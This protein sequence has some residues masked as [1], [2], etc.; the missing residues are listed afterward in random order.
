MNFI[1]EIFFEGRKVSKPVEV[2][3]GIADFFK[4]HFSKAADF[5]P[6][7]SGLGLKG[8]SEQEI[9]V[10]ENPFCKE[11]IWDA[12]RGCD[13]NTA[14]GPDGMNL[15]F[16]KTNWEMIQDD[17]GYNV[18][19]SWDKCDSAYSYTVRV[20]AENATDLV[21]LIYTRKTSIRTYLP[22]GNYKVKLTTAYEPTEKYVFGPI[23]SFKVSDD[24]Q[25]SYTEN[26][27][28]GGISDDEMISDV[29]EFNDD[30]DDS[31]DPIDISDLKFS[32]AGDFIYTG[33]RI[34]PAVSIW[35]DGSKLRKDVD[36][37][38]SYT[39]NT[40]AGKATITIKGKGDYTGTVIKSFN[41][42][43]AKQ[44]INPKLAA[45]TIV[46]GKSTTIS[47]GKAIG[48]ITYTAS[49]P[50]VSV[51]AKGK[52]QAKGVGAAKIVVT[53]AGDKNH[54]SVS[55][56]LSLVINPAG[57]AITK[58]KNPSRGQVNV[59]WGKNATATGYELQY[60]TSANFKTNPKKKTINSSQTT[61]TT[62]KKLSRK[63][64]YLRIR[65]FKTVGGRKYYSAWSKSRAMVLNK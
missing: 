12:V 30:D 62:I 3:E 5:R 45:D 27:D 36:Y 8:L 53:A 9:A 39:N 38:V 58:I 18:E 57:V 60:S 20:L 46:Q 37:S 25:D 1:G 28:S 49:S 41:I 29:P 55:K 61:S 63:K 24:N 47:S 21:N 4:N 16:I 31:F 19:I 32:K 10:L 64:W 34:T 50:I 15:N 59:V 22:N 17:L 65:T 42:N 26:N 48:K 11:E 14:P 33:S 13:G 40:N 56:T 51:S 43:K 35:D 2:R 23:S 52:V 7:F 6:E 44:T 54:A